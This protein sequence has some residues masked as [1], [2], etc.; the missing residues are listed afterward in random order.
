MSKKP[1][2][3]PEEWSNRLA[4]VAISKEDMNAIIANYLFTE[5][6]SAAARNFTREANI[7]PP[8][9]LESIESRMAIRRAVQSGQVENATIMVNELDPE[10]LDTNPTLH[11]HLLQLQL[12]ELIRHGRIAEALSFAQL[13]LAPKGEENPQF[14]KELERTMALLAFELPKL[15]ATGGTVVTAPAPVPST[16]GKRSKSGASSATASAADAAP[17][18]M[19]EAISSLLD[20][21]QRLRTAAELNAAILS[22]QSHSKDPKLPGLMKMLVWGET[23][24]AEKGAE[25]PKWDFHQ[26]LAPSR[27]IDDPEAMML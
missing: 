9:D 22:A 15:A 10:I 6:Y 27:S 2:T 14:L 7:Q 17:P 26:L 25:F 5:G 11:F 3:T 16:T 4:G 19:P 1:V 23:M 8:I 24:L 13:E 20:Q 18:P 21:S 12:I